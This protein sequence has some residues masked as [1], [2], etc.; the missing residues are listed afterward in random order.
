MNVN[1]YIGFDVHKKTIIHS[2]MI[3][4]CQVTDVLILACVPE[5]TDGVVL[6]PPPDGLL[7]HVPERTW[8]RVYLSGA[9]LYGAVSFFG[10]E[11]LLLIQI[12]GK[13]DQSFI[14]TYP[15]FRRRPS[16]K[17]EFG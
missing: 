15:A 11:F 6:T 4:V 10:P 14:C 16:R 8:T 1:H 12:N 2:F 3:G 17:I 5:G 7:A 9:Y 13:R